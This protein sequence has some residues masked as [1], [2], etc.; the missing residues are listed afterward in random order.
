MKRIIRDYGKSAF[1]LAD[2]SKAERRARF[3][4]PPNFKCDLIYYFPHSHRYVH[5]AMYDKKGINDIETV[6]GWLSG[7]TLELFND[8]KSV[9]DYLIRVNRADLF[10][11]VLPHIFDHLNEEE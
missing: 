2:F 9:Y 7:C 6:D 11:T 8:D 1:Y 3:S 10:P 4:I 5:L